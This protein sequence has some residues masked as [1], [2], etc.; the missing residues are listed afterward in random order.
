MPADRPHH[1]RQP[2]LTA[3]ELGF[4]TTETGWRKDLGGHRVSFHPLRTVSDLLP[5]EAMQ[6]AIF[7]VTDRDLAAASALVV[8]AETGGEVIGAFVGDEPTLAGVVIGWGGFVDGRPRLLSDMLLVRPDVRGAGLGAALKAIQAAVALER[9]YQTIVWTVDPLRA[10]NARL[11]FEKL[12]AYA[13]HY[14]ENRYGTGFAAGLYGDLPS[15]RLHL[16][17]VLPDPSVKRRLLGRILPRTAAAVAGLPPWSPA[18]SNTAAMQALVTRPSDVDALLARDPSAV[19]TWRFALRE[20]L[21]AAFAAG[22]AITGFVGGVGA[23]GTEAVYLVERRS[24]SG[25]H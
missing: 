12:G 16:T 1:A 3:D 23:T 13:D 20:T 25:G 2:A 15:D 11:N 19:R 6:Q 22:W 18:L 24:E 5:V 7:G 8:V 10:A 4:L 14:E 17:W 21:Q 9:G